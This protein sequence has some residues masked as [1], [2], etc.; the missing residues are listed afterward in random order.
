MLGHV[1]LVLTA[2]VHLGKEVFDW[3][4]QKIVPWTDVWYLPW[5]LPVAHVFGEIIKKQEL[6]VIDRLV[7][8]DV[9]RMP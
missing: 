1:A 9:F 6:T 8:S 2:M 5:A 7:V 4:C 3:Y